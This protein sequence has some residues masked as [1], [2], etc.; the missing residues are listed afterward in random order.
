LINRLLPTKISQPICAIKAILSLNCPGRLP[1]NPPVKKIAISKSA[2][3]SKFTQTISQ[4]IGGWPD[5]P[6][7]QLIYMKQYNKNKSGSQLK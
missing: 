5:R 6:I 4:S 1:A 7:S 2:L 3:S